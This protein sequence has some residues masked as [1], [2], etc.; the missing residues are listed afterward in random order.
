MSFTLFGDDTVTATKVKTKTKKRVLRARV[1]DLAIVRF[2]DDQYV[3]I[4]KSCGCYGENGRGREY[5]FIYWDT[6]S[7]KTEVMSAGLPG[8]RLIRARP[9]MLW[10]GSLSELTLDLVEPIYENE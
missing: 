8:H 2:D 3:G 10:G 6:V 1:G 5:T 4:V 9:R 7:G